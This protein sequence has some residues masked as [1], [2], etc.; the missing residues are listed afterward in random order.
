MLLDSP[1]PPETLR[2]STSSSIIS[3]TFPEPTGA[4]ASK[5]AELFPEDGSDLAEA[6]FFSFGGADL[7]E[8]FPFLGVLPS[9]ERLPG[10]DG[11][12]FIITIFI[13]CSYHGWSQQS[14]KDSRG[15]FVKS[16]SF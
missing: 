3:T 15:D 11:Y 13:T 4:E 6:E 8:F 10:L 9:S 14:G 7:A 12:G 1:E 16:A 2:P 5:D